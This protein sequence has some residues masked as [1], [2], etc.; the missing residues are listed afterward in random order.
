MSVAYDRYYSKVLPGVPTPFV[1]ALN[2][3]TF[4]NARLLLAHL[5][6]IP[7]KSIDLLQRRMRVAALLYTFAFAG[8][9]FWD[10]VAW[11]ADQ[12]V[13]FVAPG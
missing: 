13:P 5:E 9:S 6:R 2:E 4:Y 3:S 10:V 12:R 8:A 1:I 7:P 11:T